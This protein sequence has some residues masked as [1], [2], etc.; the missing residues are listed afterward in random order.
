MEETEAGQHQEAGLPVAMGVRGEPRLEADVMG[1]NRL[2]KRGWKQEA[3]LT[4]HCGA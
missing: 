1:G 2:R 3:Q 4:G